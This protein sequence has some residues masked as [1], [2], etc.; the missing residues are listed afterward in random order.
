MYDQ[1]INGDFDGDGR[2]DDSV[3]WDNDTGNFVVHSWAGFRATY[4]SARRV[5]SRCTTR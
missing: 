1:L 3:L 2:A 5:V 4:R